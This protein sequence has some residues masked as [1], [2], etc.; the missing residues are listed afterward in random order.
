MSPRR[1]LDAE[2]LRRGLVASRMEAQELIA[3]GSV[4]VDGAPA[5][6]A[7]RQVSPGVAL[8]VAGP[9][10]RFVSRGGEKLEAALEHFA[11]SV[12]GRSVLDAGASTGGFSDCVL[13]RG[14]ARVAA[15]D[16]GYGQLHERIRADERVVVFD[17]TNLRTIDASFPGAPFDLVV[18]DLA[19]I[20]LTKVI[21][22]LLS[23][24]RPGGDLVLLVKPQFEAD[25][26][27]AARARGIITDP[28]VQRRTLSEVSDAFERRGAVPR[29][30]M[31]SPIRGADGNVEFLLHLMAPDERMG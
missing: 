2:M 6:N 23:A 9:R 7:S 11:V 12:A 28:E 20:S 22:P 17:R 5:L 14:A 21:E 16:V 26:E 3:A 13:Q 4:T 10:P 30:S 15:L 29:G 31:T 25:R 19:F 18:A 24:C 27:E 1:S 8:N